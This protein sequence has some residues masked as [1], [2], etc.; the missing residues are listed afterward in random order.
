[1]GFTC[2][3]Q[4]HNRE[5]WNYCWN[6]IFFP[7]SV[8]TSALV[9]CLNIQLKTVIRMFRF[10]HRVFPLFWVVKKEAWSLNSSRAD[11]YQMTRNRL[12]VSAGICLPLSE[13]RVLILLA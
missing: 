6:Q 4:L 2:F 1:M 10:D 5:A 8:N 3:E 11:K 12:S 7:Y 9:C 13:K